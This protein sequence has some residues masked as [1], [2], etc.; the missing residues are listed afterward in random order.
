MIISE[1]KLKSRLKV[2]ERF[3]TGLPWLGSQA[4]NLK[5]KGL[6]S[7]TRQASSTAPIQDN[8]LEETSLEPVQKASLQGLLE[9]IGPV[10]PLSILLGASE[11]GLPLTLNLTNPTPGALLIA[12]DA[13]SGKTRFIRS[14]LYSAAMINPAEQVV[15]HIIAANLNEY[16]DLAELD[17]CLN[18]F[19]HTDLATTPLLEELFAESEK[20]RLKPAKPVIL[21]II[22]D[23][24]R[25]MQ[26]LNSELTAQL[27]RL[28]KHGPR[29]GIW[30]I[31]S[32][33]SEDVE[34][35]YPA[36]L[37]AFR[38]HLIGYISDPVLAGYL[39]RDENCPAGQLEKGS[40]LCAVVAGE[41]LIFQ[42]Y[43]PVGG[44][45]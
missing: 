29:L 9:A 37:E 11:D 13:E 24:P 3:K 43:D 23:I 33:S 20:R 30:V 32:V 40:Q 5:L 14:V 10:E 25:L 4:H 2:I 15:F 28:I 45:R 18:L 36:L 42:L 34:H 35:A 39:A 31:A 19:S 7:G 17:N 44:V 38:T 16:T 8:A 21:L 12:G 26:S 1:D 22:E 27:Y 41:W 6:R